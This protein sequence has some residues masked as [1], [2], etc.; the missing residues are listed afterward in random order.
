MNRVRKRAAPTSGLHN[1]QGPQ[2]REKWWGYAFIAPTAIG[3]AIFDL[4]PVLRT[5][6]FSFTKWGPFG[7]ATWVGL[8]NYARLAHDPDLGRALTNSLLYTLVS[9]AG[10]SLAVLL[11]V[12]LNTKGV[13]GRGLL[14]TLYF[15]PVVTIPAAVA[16][17][18]RLIYNG[19]Y[20]VLNAGL[21]LLHLPPR[22]WLTSPATALYAVAAVG[23]WSSIGTNIIIFLAGLQG[24]PRELYEA[25][26]IDGAGPV[27]KFFSVTLPMLSPSIFFVSVLTVIASLQVFDAI[28]LMIGKGNPALPD[29]RTV[30]YLFY[31]AAFV[32]NDRG[33]AAAIAFVLLGVTLAVT[34]IQ[35]RLQRRWVHYA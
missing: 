26:S 8:A 2:G 32:H 33:Y 21:A 20:G 12:L 17:M 11:A 24:I 13:V 19:D 22:S 16:I 4:W 25:A 9:L 30:V 27:R 15:L 10:I 29:T 18:W 5:F 31:E 1:G 28:Y 3:L 23:V 35:F 14:R 34:L 6:Y 7:G